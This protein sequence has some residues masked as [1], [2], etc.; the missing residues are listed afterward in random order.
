MPQNLDFVS[1]L[2]IK[3]STPWY[4]K[5]LFLIFTYLLR[6]TL[7]LIAPYLSSL[8]RL[9]YSVLP[10]FQLYHGFI[11]L[12]TPNLLRAIHDFS[13][14]RYCPDFYHTMSLLHA[15]TNFIDV[16]LDFVQ[17]KA[18]PWFWSYHGSPPWY[19]QNAPC[20]SQFCSRYGSNLISIKPWVYFMLIMCY[21]VL[22]STSVAPRLYPI[23]LAHYSVLLIIL[24]SHMRSNDYFLIGL[25]F[26][27]C[28][29]EQLLI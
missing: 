20:D 19:S 29:M 17:A 28:I 15:T 25:F 3:G 7:I 26:Y 8:P 10:K 12:A 18:L 4:I 2:L 24:S 23:L 11:T 9:I 13:E 27:T 14:T 1:G 21:S 6:T 22:M 16:T 5:F